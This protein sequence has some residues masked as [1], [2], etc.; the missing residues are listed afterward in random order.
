MT[1]P[2]FVVLINMGMDGGDAGRADTF[3]LLGTWPH[4]L[5]FYSDKE[6]DCKM[7]IE[8]TQEAQTTDTSRQ[9][10]IL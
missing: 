2:F 10:V 3:A 6:K 5:F 9:T 8:E 7:K 1:K 4:M